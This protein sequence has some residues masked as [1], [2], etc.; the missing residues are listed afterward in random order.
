MPVYNTSEY[1]INCVN[2]LLNQTYKSY[3]IILVDD[4][5]TDSSS[6]LCDFLCNKYP[7]KIKVIHQVNQGL[8]CARKTAFD[9]ARGD[10]YLCVDSDDTLKNTALEEIV[11]I[12]EATNSDLIFYNW[13]KDQNFKS[14]SN[15]FISNDAKYLNISKKELYY[16]FFCSRKLNNMWIHAFSGNCISAVKCVSFD[17]RLQYGED[18]LWNIY[19][20]KAAKKITYLDSSLY[21]YRQNSNSITHS[22]NKD[23]MDDIF[24]V[25]AELAKFAKTIFSGKELSDIKEHISKIDILQI[26]DL[27]TMI[28]LSSN[29]DKLKL[30]IELRQCKL[31]KTMH[32]KSLFSLRVDYLV[33]YLLFNKTYYKAY[34]LFSKFE[35]SI[36]YL[37]SNSLVE[38]NRF[39]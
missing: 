33:K 35:N 11:S 30:L 14:K 8:F 2:S 22:F 32:V 15:L 24:F 29:S 3:E 16:N 36:R 26:L 1:L 31:Y 28:S 17:K 13:S 23:R 9:N 4:G 37:V 19:I 10:I 5:S 20:Y 38:N 21:F 6:M 39:W 12:Y 27:A 34:I 25:R 7:Q 18:V